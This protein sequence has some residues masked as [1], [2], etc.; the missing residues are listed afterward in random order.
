MRPLRGCCLHCGVKHRVRHGLTVLWGVKNEP[1]VELLER[2]EA[3]EQLDGSWLCKRRSFLYI[4]D[5]RTSIPTL[6]DARALLPAGILV[7]LEFSGSFD[8]IEG[9]WWLLGVSAVA[10][11]T[12]TGLFWRKALSY[13]GSLAAYR[14]ERREVWSE[15]ERL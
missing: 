11:I 3:V 1:A 2:P 10:V 13:R 15:L 5:E 8:Q 7:V 12:Y 9:K 14:L 6:H 4:D